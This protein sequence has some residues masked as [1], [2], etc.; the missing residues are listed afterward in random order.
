[1][2]WLF[3][4]PI[5]AQGWGG[6][7]NW[8]LK[9]GLGFR[10]R[11]DRCL[12]VGR[13]VSP[14][15]E[16]CRQH[17]LPF[18]P[19]RFGVDLA[20]WTLLALHRIAADF[21]PDILIAKGFRQVR[22]ARVACPGVT[23]GVK[24][25]IAGELTAEFMDRLTFRLGADRV[26]V[27]NEFARQTCLRHSWVPPDK[28]VTVHNGVAIPD[29]AERPTVRAQ[30]CREL[31]LPAGAVLVG[32]AGRFTPEKRYADALHAFAGAAAT[33]KARLVLF[34]EGPEQPAL[35]S[36]AASLNIAD[37]VHFPGWRNNA[38]NWL[39]A[40]D[41]V[42]HPSAVEGLPNVVLE[43]MAGGAAVIASDAGGTREIL[44]TPDVG[45]LYAAGDVAR[46]TG[47]LS[48]L[49][50][51]PDR[52]RD[53]GR[54]ALAH[55][56]AHFSIPVM[57]DVVRANLCAAH[58]VRSGRPLPLDSGPASVSPPPPTPRFMLD[59]MLIRLGK[60]L[61]VIGCD[62]AWDPALRTHD[63]IRRAN[64]EDRVFVTRNRQL[65]HQYPR[66]AALLTL[67]ETDPKAQFD[68]VVAHFRLEPQGALFTRCIR[69]NVIL[70]A[71]ADKATIQSRVDPNVYRRHDRFYSCPSCG[72]VFWYGSHVT[73]TC[74][75]LELARPD[76]PPA[77]RT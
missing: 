72:T 21:R 11:G 68:R 60:Y 29:P 36:L 41:I 12:V 47:H 34:G 37:R 55:V 8:M 26:L 42:L 20:P 32:G 46:L 57:V 4:N 43:A 30:I 50:S 3:L 59:N 66:P 27:D 24:L 64:A 54:R 10:E 31:G 18:A 65:P 74:R 2:N 77:A 53:L 62:A 75:K 13:A 44:T 67:V 14:W 1:M 63:L 5:K 38:R 70:D 22:F 73:N 33:T 9:L 39:P 51:D 58:A 35:Q 48:D 15:P 23:I 6:M 40:F 16:V 28:V 49:L 45:C 71:V 19:I 25:P 56:A 61:R 69:C 17:N 7:E 76:A 52:R